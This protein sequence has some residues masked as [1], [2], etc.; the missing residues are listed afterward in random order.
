MQQRL[1]AL[2]ETCQ[3]AEKSLSDSI[4]TGLEMRL[5]RLEERWRLLQALDPMNVLMR[6]YALA[7]VGD[8]TVTSIG[9]LQ[10]G[11]TF[12]LRMHDGSANCRVTG[13]DEQQESG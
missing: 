8:R 6:G 3:Q 11:T 9:Q 7:E 5:Q 1:L 4:R 12:M 13:D 2:Q 10:T